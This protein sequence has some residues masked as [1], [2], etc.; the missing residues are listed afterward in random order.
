MPAGTFLSAIIHSYWSKKCD[1]AFQTALIRTH[2][3]SHTISKSW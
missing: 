1:I 3:C 2:K